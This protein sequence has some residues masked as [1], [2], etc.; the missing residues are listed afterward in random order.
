M[1]H[2]SYKKPTITIVQLRQKCHILAGS[3][4]S[5]TAGLRNS[6]SNYTPINATNSAQDIPKAGVE[7]NLNFYFAYK[8]YIYHTLTENV[9]LYYKISLLSSHFF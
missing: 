1:K 4:L 9:F 5:N 6:T 8:D 2:K 3:K 7:D